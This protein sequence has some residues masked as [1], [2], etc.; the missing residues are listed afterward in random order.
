GSHP[1]WYRSVA[2]PLATVVT[3]TRWDPYSGK[4]PVR[5]CAGGRSVM[6][7]PT[8]S[9][10]VC[11]ICSRPITAHVGPAAMSA[12]RP[13]PGGQRTSKSC[14]ARIYEYTAWSVMT[15]RDMLA[16][17]IAAVQ[18][19]R[20][21]PPVANLC[22]NHTARAKPALSLALLE[23]RATARFLKERRRRSVR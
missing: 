22:C 1:A 4:P 18:P 19:T 7:V 10:V 8:A 15:H 12:V 17:R 14:P 2:Q 5:L 11:C 13:L 23:D 3:H 20:G 9:E 21:I 6:G 16:C